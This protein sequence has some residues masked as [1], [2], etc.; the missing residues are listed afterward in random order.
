MPEPVAGSQSVDLDVEAL[1]R[2]LDDRLPGGG[3]PLVVERM[4]VSVGMANALFFVRRAGHV[5]VL[6]RRPR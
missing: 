5:W 6:R 4:G 3:D 2:W 1:G